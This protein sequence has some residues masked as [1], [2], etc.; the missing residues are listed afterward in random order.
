M[1][2]AIKR[3]D[4]AF[5]QRNLGNIADLNAKDQAGNSL[6][7]ALVAPARIILPQPA[8]PQ[9]KQSH[10]IIGRSGNTVIYSS[11]A[12]SAAGTAIRP[13]MAVAR[14]IRLSTLPVSDG[15]IHESLKTRMDIIR[16]LVG[17]GVPIN[18]MNAKHQTPLHLAAQSDEVIPFVLKI[19]SG[20]GE[21]ARDPLQGR[22][23]IEFLISL[24]ADLR[25]GDDEGN[26]PLFLASSEALPLLVRR[27]A[28]LNDRDRNGMSPFLKA[29][30]ANALAL[31]QLGADAHATDAQ[32]RN[33]WFFL[34]N[35]GWEELADQMLALRVNI[36]QKDRQG[37]SAL[38]AYSREENFKQAQFL[39]EHGVD[40]TLADKNGQTPLHAATAQN[41]LTLMELLLRK[42]AAINARDRFGATP[43]YYSRSNRKSAEM[44]LRCKADPRIPTYAGKNV[45]HHLVDDKGDHAWEMLCLFVARGVPVNRKNDQGRTPLV[46]AY[47]RDNTRAMKLLL[48]NGADPGISG[49]NKGWS[50][51]DR[52]EQEKN[53][54]AASLLRRYGARHARPWWKRH[55]E[56]LIYGFIGLGIFPLF[57]FI[58]SLFKPSLF[59]KKLLWFFL[60]P[61][62]GY[63]VV[64]I[65]LLAGGFPSSDVGMAIAI[66]SLPP[67]TALLM[68]LSGTRALAD[69]VAPIL[70]IPLSILNAAGC[71]GL[72]FGLVW[73]YAPGSTQGEGGLA[74]VL[75]AL[76]GG[77]AAAVITLIY[78]IFAWKSAAQ[79]RL[80]GQ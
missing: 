51:L 42:G 29:M 39:I 77:G 22:R 14:P 72:T 71:M 43:L 24:G 62:A 12:N 80:K 19:V 7:H 67:L 36:D 79:V 58:F 40:F 20:R 63:L 8:P 74:L 73:L 30:P 28:S 17:L 64:W 66:L 59:T 27:G 44:L 68:S 50:L 33:R 53:K 2:A 4:L 75:T 60:A 35:A 49:Y 57:S 65:A 56:L 31:L 48:E 78:A 69:R 52:A 9:G 13:T 25:L 6:I 45:L 70:G 26:T 32:G 46:L 76:Y 37:R 18:G 61:A 55:Q 3:D 23:F 1:F 41:N 5:V 11:P 54:E 16:R 21:P 15:T 34:P 10:T 47:M 38:M